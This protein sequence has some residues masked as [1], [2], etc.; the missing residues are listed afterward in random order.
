[1]KGLHSLLAAVRDHS[2]SLATLASPTSPFTSANYEGQ[3]G[4]YRLLES[5]QNDI[6]SSFPLFY[7][8]G[9]SHQGP[10]YS[11]RDGGGWVGWIQED[12]GV[13]RVHFRSYL[14][15][16]G[17]WERSESEPAV[18]ST[19]LTDPWKNYGVLSQ[20]HRCKALHQDQE[21]EPRTTVTSET[22]WAPLPETPQSSPAGFLP[23]T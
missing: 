6:P 20:D 5:H 4:E 10:D 3:G 2:Q 17:E 11:R 22:D 19:F 18:I 15:Q 14:A 13:I 8:L 21:E 9:V 12:V 23:L 7:W 16:A 1:M